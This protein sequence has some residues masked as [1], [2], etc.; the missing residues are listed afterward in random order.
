[1]LTPGARRLAREQNQSRPPQGAATAGA[2]PAIVTA[3]SGG[4]ATVSYRGATQQVAHLASYTPVVNDNV[5]LLV[6]S[7]GALVILGKP[8][9]TPT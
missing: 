6:M 3:Y 1:V 5:L 2:G 8:A 4:I 9:G 7:D